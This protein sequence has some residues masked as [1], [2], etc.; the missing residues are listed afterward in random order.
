MKAHLDRITIVLHRPKHPGNVGSVA[1]AMKNMGLHRLRLVSPCDFRTDIAEWMAVSAKEVLKGAEVFEDLTA[2]IAESRLVVGTIPPDRPRFEA[3]AEA[4]DF[5]ARRLRGHRGGDR[6]S[7]LFGPED[8]GLTNQ[9]LDLCHEFVTIPSHP[10]FPALN[11]AQSVMVIAYEIFRSA[12]NGASS[13]VRSTADL[14]TLEQMYAHM[15]EALLSIG[16]LDPENPGHIMRDI[17]RILGRA[18]LSEREVRILR[19]ILRQTKW[20]AGRSAPDNSGKGST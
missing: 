17:R 4:P 14:G 1:R 10:D 18:Q 8:T 3:E 19:G 7:I 6:I 13:P 20:A 16:F 5:L 2:A 12:Q 9:E 15:Q 11:L